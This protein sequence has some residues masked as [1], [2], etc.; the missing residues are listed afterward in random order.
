VQ[1]GR[2]QAE[3]REGRRFCGACGFPLPT[4]C[5]SCG[6]AN[7]G[8]E[9]FCGGC[10]RSLAAPAP[11][12]EPKFQS[13]EAYTPKHLSERI[14]SSRTALE[15]ERK[16]VTVLFADLKSSMELLADRD[17]EDARAIL[18][19][20]LELMMAAVHGFEGTVNQVMGD[21][22]MALFGAPIAHEDHAVRACYAALRMQEAVRTYAVSARRSHGVEV[23]IR[24]G[25]NS[26]EVVVRS[27]GSDL[28]MDYSAIGQT[29]HLAARMEQL[30]TP[31]TIRLTV[32]TLRL[33]EGFVEVTPLGPV[34][35]KGILEPVEV[36][37]MTGAGVARTRLQA[38][39][40]RGLSPFR[41]RERELEQL[42]RAQQHA[43]EGRGQVVAL[44]GEAG[45]GKSRLVYE[46]VHS[47]RL[48][49]WSI[50]E[51]APVSYGKATSYYPVID[52]LKGYFKIQSRDES[53]AIREKVTGK[54]LTLDETLKPTL[55][56]LLSLLDVPIDDDTEWRALDPG[57][58]RRCTLDAVT[59]LLLREAREQPLLLIF[60]D[61]HW[62]DVETQ[63]V[64]DGLVASLGTAR[65]LLLA[66][67]RPEYAHAWS[68]QPHSTQMRLSALAVESAGELLDALLG[69]DH[70]LAP[71]KQRLVE[72][73]NPFFLEETVRTLVETNLLVG[74]PGRYRLTR[75][76]HALEVPP[77]VQAVLAARIDRLA[78]EDKRLLQTASVVGNDIPLSVL[79]E[80]AELP[81]EALRRALD[82][83]RAAEFVYEAKLFPEIEYTFT[84]ALTH[85][86]AYGGLLHER[87]RGL[88]ARIVDAIERIYADRLA[89]H[90]ER[91]ADHALRG[92]VW[93]KAVRYLR[94]AVHRQ[95]A[96]SAYHEARGSLEIA[97][98]AL[99]RLPATRETQVQ[100]IDLRLDSRVVLAPL[101]QYDRIL[102]YMREA[103][104]IARQL[105]DRRRLGLVLADMG[106]RLRNVGDHRHALDASQQALDIAAEL[107]DLGLQIEARYRL[108]QAH[109]AV[110]EF[111]QAATMFRR[112]IEAVTA[113]GVRLITCRSDRSRVPPRFFEAWPHAW[114]ALALGQLGRFGEALRH[115][116]DAM[117]IAESADHLHTLVESYGAVGGV[118]LEHGDLDR[119]RGAFERGLALVRPRSAGDVNL[120]SGLGYAYA[121]SGRPREAVPLLE[122]SIHKETSM[123]AMGLGLSV[124]TTRL[125]TTYLSAG[126]REDALTCARSAV[127]LST[128]HHERA[129]QALAL[130]ALADIT[131][132]DDAAG[133]GDA[134]DLY[135]RSLA[136]AN[137]LGMRPLVAHCHA[138][139]G[140]LH[141]RIGPR[142]ESDQHFAAAATMYREM[143][144]TYWLE[145]AER[146]VNE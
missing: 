98:R 15:G 79:Q 123:S 4:T 84:H 13:P 43:G 133:P 101:G 68:D 118:H 103:E 44:V 3:N 31:G 38:A 33:A 124:R 108:A 63:A 41:G 142:G 128:K 77:T 11:A 27:V 82:R 134:A 125:A 131:A 59:R 39:V 21:G 126:R 130:K 57:E 30:A 65:L 80:I 29:T 91:L 18:D 115:A 143:G 132:C 14:L 95:A 37:E 67:H 51:A 75:P 127:E 20:V 73:G 8:H 74:Q 28:R 139:L 138:G 22:I 100:A 58:R 1:C 48:Q 55:P 120:L 34:P 16:R 36:F 52:L 111:E 42:G 54:V 113:G 112:A 90:V 117:S 141:R 104:V 60:E 144:M 105:G 24:V 107:G 32:D 50:L 26:G 97:L 6:F 136:L 70:A 116:E 40:L 146:D 25:L 140:K 83:L 129:N 66:T 85:E 114:L 45:V 17:P 9:R 7:E 78:P 135:S 110:G 76:I 12:S 81:D 62:I 106:A 109:F 137:E 92:E 87:R 122:D 64:L 61:L 94:D 35:V 10:G 89:E 88:H 86:V 96:R 49:D 72:H 5:P 53:R 119:A 99:A 23:Q 145:Q 102:E 19:P 69:P 56:A 47:P 2:C 71:L 93:D 121:L 46:F